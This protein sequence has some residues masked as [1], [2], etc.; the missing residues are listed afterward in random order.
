MEFRSLKR[1]NLM[2]EI[3]KDALR[4]AFDKKLKMGNSDFYYFESKGNKNGI[5]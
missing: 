3:R 5:Q 1:K 2:G 4:V